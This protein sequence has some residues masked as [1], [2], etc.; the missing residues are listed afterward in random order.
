MKRMQH[1]VHRI[2][3]LV[4]TYIIVFQPCSETLCRSTALP[5]LSGEH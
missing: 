3:T 5:A 1:T 2:M 4:I